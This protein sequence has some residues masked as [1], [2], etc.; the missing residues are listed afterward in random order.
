[1]AGEIREPGWT[2]RR[3]V[4]G[5]TAGAAA[6]V[7]GAALAPGSV[8]AAEAAGGAAG[9][10]GSWI[11]TLTIP[12]GDGSPGGSFTGGVVFHAD[13]TLIAVGAPIEA[14]G[15][16]GVPPELVAHTPGLGAWRS[17]GGDQVAFTFV[18][19]IYDATE[20]FIGRTTF[21]G[22]GQLVAP[23]RF[24]A[25]VTILS[26]MVD[27]EVIFSVAGTLQLNQVEV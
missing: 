21:R 26:T 18:Q 8:R 24:A 3:R 4:L 27:G 15:P 25:Q 12:P 1:M 11:G 14:S 5:W 20:T 22:T 19:L 2:S 9:V 7:G 23:D 16:P 17:S 6:L 10:V 13:G